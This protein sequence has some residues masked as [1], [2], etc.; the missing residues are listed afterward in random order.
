MQMIELVTDK[1][2]S[3]MA[4]DVLL[5]GTSKH[6]S[7]HRVYL[8]M[9]QGILNE[10]VGIGSHEYKVRYAGLDKSGDDWVVAS[11]VSAD[12]IEN[13]ETRK[14]KREVELKDS[15]GASADGQGIG[16]EVK[17]FVAGS[18]SGRTKPRADTKQPSPAPRPPASSPRKKKQ[19]SPSAAPKVKSDVWVPCPHC[20][21]GSG[22]E[23]TQ[24]A[25]CRQSQSDS[26]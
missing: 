9:I 6:K 20:P 3:L 22:K 5:L 4:G 21:P 8:T 15:Q 1:P 17:V 23:G 26:A 12:H 16:E 25:A 10:R 19:P 13:F 24:R 18:A 2:T 11:A 7:G 14:A